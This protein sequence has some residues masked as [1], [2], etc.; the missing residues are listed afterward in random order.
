MP[1]N[2]EGPTSPEC[3]ANH[4]EEEPVTQQTESVI[5]VD[6][7][8][9]RVVCWACGVLI[10][11]P[12][13]CVPE[14]KTAIDINFQCGGC[15][16]NNEPHSVD[17]PNCSGIEQKT[18]PGLT[19]RQ[20]FL[21]LLTGRIFMVV[22]P[23]IILY[24]GVASFYLILPALHPQMLDRGDTPGIMWVH[25]AL[26]AFFEIQI[27]YNYFATAF[28]PPGSPPLN[29]EYGTLAAAADGR[30]KDFSLC[31]R[32]NTPRPPRAHHCS[33]CG[34]CAYD[35]DHHC[36][37]VNNCVGY[38]NRRTFLLFVVY[39]TAGCLYAFT[40]LS[41]AFWLNSPYFYKIAFPKC[42]PFKVQKSLAR[43]LG[44][45]VPNS[46]RNVF[47]ETGSILQCFAI[48]DGVALILLVLAS[49]LVIILVGSLLVFQLRL[50]MMDG[51]QLEMMKGNVLP[52][53]APTMRECCTIALQNAR[54]ILGSPITWLWL[55]R[56]PLPE[57]E[58]G[59]PHPRCLK[60]LMLNG[61]EMTEPGTAEP[62][63]DK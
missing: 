29:M 44:V 54:K 19:P 25:V 30:L 17:P 23:I 16:A 48:I 37:F 53:C 52:V 26:T 47:M 59:R 5:P 15:S 12:A 2:E 9:L 35:L 49:F 61:G 22:V 51:T 31:R 4:V 7:E 34:T 1:S 20:K 41:C 27:F 36:I 6:V 3:D 14:G 38:G 10:Q 32:C 43:M 62:K 33:V 56:G 28:T 24:V 21:R 60:A 46:K 39:A 8:R 58:G 11:L 18:N 57:E 13:E 42:M 45:F 55:R 50:I 63:K 40:A